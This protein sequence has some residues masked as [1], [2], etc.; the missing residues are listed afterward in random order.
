MAEEMLNERD[1]YHRYTAL[2]NDRNLEVKSGERKSIGNIV[3][4]VIAD[5][6]FSNS[7]AYSK[8]IVDAYKR[9]STLSNKINNPEKG[10]YTKLRYGKVELGN[11][12]EGIQDLRKSYKDAGLTPGEI[13]LYVSQQVFGSN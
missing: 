2:R 10:L 12:W 9:M 4:G 5:Q 3:D 1:F 13:G 8:R 6:T 7:S 11:L